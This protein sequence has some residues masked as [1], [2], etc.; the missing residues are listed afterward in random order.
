[1]TQSTGVTSNGTGNRPNRIGSGV[2]ADRGQKKWF[3]TSAFAALTET[4]GTYGNAGRNIL[5]SPSTRTLDMSLVKNTDF[6]E[7]L[8]TQFRAEFFNL[9]NT[10]QFAAPNATIG[11]ASAG[12]ISSLLSNTPMRQIQFGLKVSF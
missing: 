9:A 1:V 7:R 4:T 8:H 11:S 2:L 12:I 3:D 5:M 10:P 6:F